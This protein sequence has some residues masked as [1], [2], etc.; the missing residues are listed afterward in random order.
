MSLFAHV[1]SQPGVRYVINTRGNPLY[2]T[3]RRR[4]WRGRGDGVCVCV[5]LNQSVIIVV[6]FI[7]NA[8]L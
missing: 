8:I 4:L 6:L 1:V 3:Y 5:V 7:F 2:A